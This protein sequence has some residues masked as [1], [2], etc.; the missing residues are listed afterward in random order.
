MMYVPSDHGS[1]IGQFGRFWALRRYNYWTDALKRNLA[2]C[3]NEGRKI[4]AFLTWVIW[5]LWLGW[6][7]KSESV[8][9]LPTPLPLHL[10]ALHIHV[11][12][13]LCKTESSKAQ[14]TTQ[15]VRRKVQQCKQQVSHVRQECTDRAA[16]CGPEREKGQQEDQVFLRYVYRVVDRKSLRIGDWNGNKKCMLE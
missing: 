4:V 16:E 15:N 12:C 9:G 13:P 14:G 11:M 1:E 6:A 2:H 5:A 8:L 7:L 10:C 3:Q